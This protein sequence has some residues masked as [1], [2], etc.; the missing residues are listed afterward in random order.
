MMIKNINGRKAGGVNMYMRQIKVDQKSGNW[1]YWKDDHW[2]KMAI[3]SDS[4]GGCYDDDDVLT[5]QRE[6]AKIYKCDA[7]T[8]DVLYQSPKEAE[9]E[10]RHG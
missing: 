1:A 9:E 2:I 5:A 8:I 4:L 3:A 7:G 10:K 6:A